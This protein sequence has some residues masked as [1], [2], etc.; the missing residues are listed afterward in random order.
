MSTLEEMVTEVLTVGVPAI[1]HW[2]TSIPGAPVPT[3]TVDE[4]DDGIEYAI[5]STLV[6]EGLLAIVLS[7]GHGMGLSK[8][9]RSIVRDRFFGRSDQPFDPEEGDEILQVALFGEVDWN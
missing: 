4:D 1:G 8:G 9:L 5:D 6:V 7:D 2:S 3:V